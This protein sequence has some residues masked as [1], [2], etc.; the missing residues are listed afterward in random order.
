MVLEMRAWKPYVRS[1]IGNILIIWEHTTVHSQHQNPT[2]I[3]VAPPIRLQVGVLSFPILRIWRSSVQG[4]RLMQMPSHPCQRAYLPVY[5]ICRLGNRWCPRG[6]S[7]HLFRLGKDASRLRGVSVYRGLFCSIKGFVQQRGILRSPCITVSIESR[8]SS[9]RKTDP[10]LRLPNDALGDFLSFIASSS[11][12]T[13]S[14]FSSKFWSNSIISSSLG[15]LELGPTAD[16]FWALNDDRDMSTS[17]N[18]SWRD[19]SRSKGA[20]GP[21]EWVI[22]VEDTLRQKHTALW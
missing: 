2:P 17:F 21:W 19:G 16:L 13:S 15:I 18:S 6:S 4:V 7:R 5:G 9:G 11:G 14:V 22:V 10:M 12:S 3:Y 1:N 8:N 20:F